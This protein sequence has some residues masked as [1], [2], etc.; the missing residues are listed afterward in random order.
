M[1]VAAQQQNTAVRNHYPGLDGLRAIAVLMVFCQHYLVQYAFIFGWG[2]AGV[3]IFFVLSGFLITGILYDSQNQ[4]F[5]YRDFYIRRTLRIFPL[6]YAVWL[7]LLLSTPLMHW[8]WSWPWVLWPAY[9]GNYTQFLFFHQAGNPYRFDLLSA[10]P[11]V[12]QWLRYPLS[13]NVGHFWS[14]CVEEQFY[15]FWP[16]IVYQVRKRETLMRICIGV[17]LV[18]PFLRWWLIKIVSPRMPNLEFLYRI[19]PTRMDALL[20]GGLIALCLRG[21]QKEWLHRWK[22]LLLAASAVL[23]VIGY[24]LAVDV[25]HLGNWVS[26]YGFTLVDLSAAALII[27]TINPHGLWVRLLSTKPIRNLGVI[28]YGFYVYHQLLYGVYA[29]LGYGFFAPYGR[30]M[31]ILIAL[32][33]SWLIAWLSYRILEFPMLKLKDRFTHQVHKAPQT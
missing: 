6:Y 31:T 20:L 32:F 21:P 14:L 3:D 28:S 1:L 18:V 5:R 24:L 8:R 10:G 23:F 15:L 29:T 26:I 17:I 4:P 2:W 25:A 7:A 33:A 12:Q 13:M 11:R 30:C 22:H 16:L 27:E 19:T 9:L